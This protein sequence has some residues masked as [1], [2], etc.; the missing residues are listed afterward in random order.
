MKLCMFGAIRVVVGERKECWE[1]MYRKYSSWDGKKMIFCSFEGNFPLVLKKGLVFVW[2]GVLQMFLFSFDSFICRFCLMFF[3]K[4]FWCCCLCVFVWSFFVFFFFSEFLM[5]VLACRRFGVRWAF[6]ADGFLICSTFCSW[7]CVSIVQHDFLHCQC[8][9]GNVFVCQR[10][11]CVS[12]FA[13]K[14]ILA[15]LAFLDLFCS[16]CC[17]FLVAHLF[18]IFKGLLKRN[19]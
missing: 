19:S 1:Q 18:G 3:L 7:S 13:V 11:S 6:G 14:F 2:G 12:T 4:V 15:A 10:I 17:P 8:L 16:C 9:F 5:D